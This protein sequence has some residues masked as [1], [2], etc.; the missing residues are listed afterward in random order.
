MNLLIVSCVSLALSLSVPALRASPVGV[1]QEGVATGVYGSDEIGS[2][3]IGSDE[4]D[5]DEIDSDEIDSDEIASEEASQFFDPPASADSRYEFSCGDSKGVCGVEYCQ[6]AYGDPYPER[7]YEMSSTESLEASYNLA[8]LLLRSDSDDDDSSLKSFC[9]DKELLQN[10][11]A[12][13]GIDELEGA[14]FWGV[15]KLEQLATGEVLYVPVKTSEWVKVG[16]V[17]SGVNENELG[18]DYQVTISSIDRYRHDALLNTPYGHPVRDWMLHNEDVTKYI[19]ASLDLVAKEDKVAYKDVYPQRQLDRAY[20]IESSTL[21]LSLTYD[22]FYGDG[23]AY[24][25]VLSGELSLPD[26]D[27]IKGL[28]LEAR[29][30]RLPKSGFGNFR[31]N[32]R[33]PEGFSLLPSPDSQLEGS[34]GRLRFIELVL[35]PKD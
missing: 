27:L 29:G 21:H 32:K 22:H 5:S 24:D 34:I 12:G 11:G 7:F 10:P 26:G 2:D 13:Y 8:S 25:A 30:A 4:L 31:L 1:A 17:I 16:K 9:I 19:S 28:K 3:E 35:F 18:V 33:D 20:L 23:L 14:T 6:E 15:V